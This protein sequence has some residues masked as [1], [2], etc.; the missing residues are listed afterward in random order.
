MTKTQE[1]DDRVQD[2]AARLPAERSCW[3]LVLLILA[4]IFLAFVNIAALVITSVI[5]GLQDAHDM[6][7]LLGS[8]SATVI[9]PLIV[10]C[11]SRL[12][13]SQR[14]VRAGFRI[15]ATVSLLILLT[16]GTSFQQI[17]NRQRAMEKLDG[18][19]NAII[20]NRKDSFLNQ[21]QPVPSIEDD[22]AKITDLINDAHSV[23]EGDEKKALEVLQVFTQ[24][25]YVISK[26]LE[27][28]LTK[29]SNEQLCNIE[30][31]TSKSGILI[32]K[33]LVQHY[34]DCSKKM[35]AYFRRSKTRLRTLLSE[36]KLS[37]KQIEGFMTGYDEQN[38][39][40]APILSELYSTHVECG[41]VLLEYLDFLHD[42]WGKWSDSKE[43]GIT[44]DDAGLLETYNNIVERIE[45]LET[46]MNALGQRLCE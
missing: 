31:L 22:F 12:W 14:N 17:G 4:S 41:N 15:F 25:T 26:E 21:S 8:A 35:S 46:R 29:V 2:Q 28:A 18:Q 33:E 38:S 6:A 34:V 1:Q 43:Q 30:N 19:I 5:I 11:I 27:T 45:L 44:F 23:V 32:Q 7:R 10:V 13:K 40:K 36:K 24:E 42:S 16:S 39:S 37:Q 9:L 20:E 3:P